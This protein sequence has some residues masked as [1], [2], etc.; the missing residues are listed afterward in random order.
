MLR[1][2]GGEIYTLA[3]RLGVSPEEI[4]DHS[5]NV[6]PLPPPVGLYELLI[7]NLSE[8]ERLSE[9]DSEGLR[10][11]LA[12]KTGLSAENILPSSGTTEWIFA[13]PRVIQPKRVLIIAP[14]YADYADAS[15]AVGAKVDYFFTRADE[16]FEPDIEALRQKIPGHEIVFICNPNNPTGVFLNQEILSALVQEFEKTVFVIDE[17]YLD[18]VGTLKDSLLSLRPF[19]KNLVVLRSFSKVYRI[20]GLRL[21]YAV[22]GNELVQKLWSVYLPWSVNRLAQIAG[23]WL[24]QQDQHLEAVRATV[25]TER[26]RIIPQIKALPGIHCFEGR[27]HFF[28]LHLKNLE[29]HHV[30]ERLL[31]DHLIL[32]RD[33]SNF[34]GLDSHYLRIALRSFE[35]NDRLI[36]ALSE[37]LAT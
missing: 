6:S 33:A 27:V 18:F 26:A 12:E 36:E 24:L 15:R 34:I 31:R 14:T 17:S 5:S 9:V 37:V 4:A 1:G 2:H 22:S 25:R 19:P 3:K 10:E 8:I 20:P 21:G 23:P 32:T 7:Q 35:E 29:A 28:L 13:I 16:N 11:A 30:W